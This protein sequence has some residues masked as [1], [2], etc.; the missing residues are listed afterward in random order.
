M[1]WPEAPLVQGVFVE[2][3]HRFGAYV[4]V[5]RK[6]EYCHVP[7]SGRLKEL[8]YPGAPVALVD[9]L[10]AR[11][12][13]SKTLR[14][15]RYAIRLA[16]YQGGWVCIE[17]NIAPR[18][19]KEAWTKGQVPQLSSYDSLRAEVALNAHTRFD[20][21]AENSRTGEKAWVEVKCVTLVKEGIGYFPDAPSE[22][23]SKHLVELTRLARPEPGQRA[24]RPKTRSFVFFILQNPRGRS[25][26]PK[27]DTD[28]LFAQKL[29]KAGQGGVRLA[30]FRARVDL[31]GSRLE[32]EVPVKAGR[33]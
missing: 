1:K 15:T 31:K 25:V 32:K 23:A 30:A 12:K 28:P 19:L 22:R 13:G 4:K 3:L 18:L 14:K 20:F 24:R 17:A 8:L 21:L 11:T 5:Q 9:H 16:V 27:E 7:N 33:T 2:R 10:R 29:R 6:K 26:A